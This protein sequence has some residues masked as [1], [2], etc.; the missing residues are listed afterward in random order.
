VGNAFELALGNPARRFVMVEVLPDQ[1]R[2]GPSDET[3]LA[4][5][6]PLSGR[7]TE[8]VVYVNDEREGTYASIANFKL[9]Q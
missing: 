2:C 3:E 1:T 5:S 7:S 8:A 4:L 9:E 6:C